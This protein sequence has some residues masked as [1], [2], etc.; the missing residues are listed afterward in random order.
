[1]NY[2]KN[3]AIALG[4][5]AAIAALIGTVGIDIQ[6]TAA[7]YGVEWHETQIQTVLMQKIAKQTS[8]LNKN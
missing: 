8:H 6:Q 1:M 7:A 5:L 2:T 3:L 4:M